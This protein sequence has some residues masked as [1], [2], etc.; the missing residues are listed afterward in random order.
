MSTNNIDP[1]IACASRLYLYD[2]KHPKKVSVFIIV[3]HQEKLSTELKEMGYLRN[4][5]GKTYLTFNIDPIDIDTNMEIKVVDILRN[6]S[7]Y[8]NGAPIFIGPN[9][10]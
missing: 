10:K 9:D 6:L 7:N 8:V 5:P 2:A 4:P 1:G 3:N